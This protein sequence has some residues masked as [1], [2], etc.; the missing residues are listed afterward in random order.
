MVIHFLSGGEQNRIPLDKV[1][2][3]LGAHGKVG[4]LGR[5]EGWPHCGDLPE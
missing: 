1:H 2:N 3:L 4:A 5:V